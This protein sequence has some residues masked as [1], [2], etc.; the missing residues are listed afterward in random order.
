[1][2]TEG[3]KQRV[4]GVEGCLACDLTNGRAFLPGGVIFETDDWLVEHCIG[5]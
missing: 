3:A 2:A 5:P 4:N 1:M